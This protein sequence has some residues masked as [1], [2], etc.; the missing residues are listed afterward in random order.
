MKKRYIYIRLLKDET[1][2]SLKE[3][4]T[5]IIKQETEI[6]NKLDSKS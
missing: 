6:I 5:K 4:Y 1:N 3:K 2:D